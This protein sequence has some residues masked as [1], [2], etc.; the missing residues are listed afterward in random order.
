MNYDS[1]VPAYK[2]NLEALNLIQVRDDNRS[3]MKEIFTHPRVY[4]FPHY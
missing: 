2:L 4:L 3:R 1:D